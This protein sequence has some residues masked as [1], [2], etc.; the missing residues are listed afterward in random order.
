MAKERGEFGIEREGFAKKLEE[1]RE[2][3]GKAEGFLTDA[4]APFKNV[5]NELK[6]NLASEEEKVG[7]LTSRLDDERQCFGKE[8][9][10]ME[11]TAGVLFFD[12]L[13]RPFAGTFSVGKVTAMLDCLEKVH[14]A[15]V[16][17]RDK[18]F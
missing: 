9:K 16:V 14:M 12:K 18:I 13:L 4:Q 7:N 1:E 11:V 8:K 17:H 15:G 3:L 5:E 2:L 6:E 10:F